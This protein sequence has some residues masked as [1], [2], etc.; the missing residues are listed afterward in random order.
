VKRIHLTITGHVQG[1]G[2]RYFCHQQAGHFGITGYARNLPDGTVEVEAQGDANAIEQFV[3]AVS[4][5][6]HNAKVT[7]VEREWRKVVPNEEGFGR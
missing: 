2:F 3:H 6:P 1:V 7:N 4:H 5:G